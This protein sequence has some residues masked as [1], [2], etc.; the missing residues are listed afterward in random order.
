MVPLYTSVV[1]VRRD[2]N[3][4]RT[5]N[6]LSDLASMYCSTCG[7]VGEPVSHDDQYRWVNGNWLSRQVKPRDTG[8]L[9]RFQAP[10]RQ[11]PAK[12][13]SS[14]CVQCKMVRS[15]FQVTTNDVVRVVELNSWRLQWK[16]QECHKLLSVSTK[17]GHLEHP[18]GLSS[19][20]TWT[21]GV[22][23]PNQKATQHFTQIAEKWNFCLKFCSKKPRR[24]RNHDCTRLYATNR[25][26]MQ[27]NTSCQHQ[28]EIDKFAFLKIAYSHTREKFGIKIN[29]NAS[30]GQNLQSQLSQ[31][32]SQTGTRACPARDVSL[33]FP[34][35]GLV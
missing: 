35:R 7:I 32:V 20:C 4:G 29:Q 23:F 14:V 3:R 28:T 13:A 10:F 15:R 18:P 2:R 11:T 16:D 6:K 12:R 33:M 5:S 27:R 31:P 25:T 24:R 8:R 26:R 19:L 30:P 22:N 21:S 34:S 1:G 9:N 17:L